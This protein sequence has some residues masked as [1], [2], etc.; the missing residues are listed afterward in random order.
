M[1]GWC[2][3]NFNEVNGSVLVSDNSYLFRKICWSSFSCGDWILKDW[4]DTDSILWQVSSKSRH[5]GFGSRRDELHQRGWKGEETCENSHY[6]SCILDVARRAAQ[7]SLSPRIR[8]PTHL[9]QRRRTAAV[10]KMGKSVVIKTLTRPT[11]LIWDIGSK[12]KRKMLVELWCENVQ[13]Y[14]APGSI[15]IWCPAQRI[16]FWKE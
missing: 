10:C 16:W 12:A 14:F 4:L 8:T 3:L 13:F 2:S 5:Q 11:C 1:L 6:Q 7:S 9:N 15:A